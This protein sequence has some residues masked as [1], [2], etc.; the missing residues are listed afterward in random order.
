VGTSESDGGGERRWVIRVVQRPRPIQGLGE[1][2]RVLYRWDERR[3]QRGMAV[4][5]DGGWAFS[6]WRVED[7]LRLSRETIPRW[8]QFVSWVEGRLGTEVSRQS[9]GALRKVRQEGEG[10][11]VKIRGKMS[12]HA[13]GRGEQQG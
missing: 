10:C 6:A 13:R 12:N 8:R 11:R 9:F 2:G 5:S 4:G 7:H 3:A 1:G